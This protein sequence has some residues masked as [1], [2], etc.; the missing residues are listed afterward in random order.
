MRVLVLAI[1]LVGITAIPDAFAGL[2]ALP[3]ASVTAMRDDNETLLS[4]TPVP[5]AI[6]YVIT[7][8][9]DPEHMAPIGEA[10]A[11]LFHAGMAA[12][13]AFYGVSTQDPHGVLSIPHIIG[14]RGD[15]LATSTS[16]QMSVS[17]QGCMNL[18]P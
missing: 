5:H 11:P 3:P 16:L 10:T 14:I 4:W 12:N 2:G 18:I 15:C 13:F 1:V 17:I 6:G 7:G 8:G 9:D